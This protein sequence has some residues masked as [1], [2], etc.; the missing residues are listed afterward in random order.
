MIL[1]YLRLEPDTLR[2]AMKKRG[3]KVDID[4]L[5]KLDKQVTELLQKYGEINEQKNKAA[6]DRDVKTGARLKKESDQLLAKLRPLQKK[7]FDMGD[8]IPNLPLSEVHPGGEDDAKQVGKPVGI[9]SKLK[10]PKDHI[11]LGAALDII[12]VERGAKVAGSRF[13]YLKNEA[14]QLEF[15]LVRMV[16]DILAKKG[17]QFLMGPQLLSEKAMMAGGYLGKAAEEVYK[18][19]DDLYLIGTSE[20]S[21]LAYHMDEIITLPKRYVSFS[22]C[23][24]REAGSYGKD[25][26][27]IIRT[28]QFDKIEMFSFVAPEASEKEHQALVEIEEEILKSLEIPYRKMLL[29]AGDLS[30]A[31]AKTIDLESW[32]PSQNKYRETHSCSNCTDWQAERA[33][34]RYKNEAG[35]N[36]YVHTLNGTAV[37]VGRLLVALLEN[38]QQKDGSI[39]VPKKLQPYCGF[40]EIKV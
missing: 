37:A 24:R 11:E 16:S 12:D 29:A 4:E 10:D 6:K 26:K 27:G 3:A 25:V 14:V 15:A 7:Q 28:H 21:M 2:A 20:Q 33:R 40:K 30:M 32:I 31:S 1:H 22:T 17:F 34:I 36:A 23:F 5:L 39:K 8:M 19:Q 9:I 35:K 18:T 38:H 13:Y